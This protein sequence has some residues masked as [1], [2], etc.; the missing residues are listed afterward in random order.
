MITLIMTSILCLKP[1]HLQETTFLLESQVLFIADYFRNP[2]YILYPHHMQH[3]GSPRS[4]KKLWMVN[5]PYGIIKA[6]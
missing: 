1:S 5:P 2:V 3:T 6:V 4:Q